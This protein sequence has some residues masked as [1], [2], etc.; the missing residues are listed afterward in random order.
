[1]V[2]RGE[3]YM[4][5]QITMA[6]EILKKQKFFEK[7]LSE[8]ALWTMYLR[9]IDLQ[10]L[11]SETVWLN[12][13][14]FDLSQLG[15]ILLTYIA[16][17]EFQ[18]LSICFFYETPTV[19]EVLQ[20]IW[21][22]FEP[23]VWE[24]ATPIEWQIGM[25]L[26]WGIP[27]NFMLSI[28]DYVKVNV[29]EE[30]QSFWFKNLLEP[31]RYGISYY[32]K[33]F[34]DPELEREAI[35]RTM[36]RLRLMRTL[37]MSWK[38]IVEYTTSFLNMPDAISKMIYNRIM[39]HYAVQTQSFMLGLSVLG[40]SRLSEV[41]GDYATAYFTDIDANTHELKFRTLDHIQ[42]GFILGV[43]PLGYGVLL[44]KKS[45]YK[46]PNGKL[47]PP[48]LNLLIS[49]MRKTINGMTLL[50]W[51]YGNYNKPEETLNYHKSERTAQYDLLQTQRRTIEEIVERM[52]PED[53]RNPIR[54][55][56]YQ[57]AILQLISWRAK[58]HRWGF[59]LWKNMTEEQFR[60]WWLG[61]W[62]SLGLNTS[63]LTSI[64]EGMELWVS[65]LRRE[66]VSLGE[67]VKRTRLQLAQYR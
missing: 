65:R 24:V 53:E 51:A 46:M 58:R 55:R 26:E 41:R 28:L 21:A 44:P 31:A 25:P 33:S 60:E 6:D 7:T 15:L 17:F 37:D 9:A 36:Y 2:E 4:S 38:N 12:L 43:T 23:L 29:S 45:I 50:P 59:D 1:M 35:R 47:N 42:M 61:Y 5:P 16:P 52:I 66:K 14:P 8:N 54:I 27:Y 34:Y 18:P 32:D 48:I 20:G 63:T 56:Q 49:K 40:K 57:N 13:A 67:K 30:Y 62:G 10:P 19:D 3:Q 11:F 22:K 39:M 64:Y